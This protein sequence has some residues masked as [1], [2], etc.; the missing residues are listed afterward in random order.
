MPFSST[1]GVYSLVFSDSKPGARCNVT[2]LTPGSSLP[3][4]AGTQAD[5]FSSCP[6][7]GGTETPVG[8]KEQSPDI[9]LLC[10]LATVMVTVIVPWASHSLSGPQA[11][12]RLGPAQTLRDTV[13]NT[14]L[15]PCTSKGNPLLGA[16]KR[17]CLTCPPPALLPPN[18]PKA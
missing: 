13:G 4:A 10:V 9:S 6:T 7:V 14:T 11:P 18:S 2:L 16:A 17:L 1:P 5:L 8:S 15:S 3:S 12:Y